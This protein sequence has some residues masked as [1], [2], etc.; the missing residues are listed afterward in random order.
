MKEWHRK[1]AVDISTFIVQIVRF[2]LP[3]TSTHAC[4][5]V[6]VCVFVCALSVITKVINEPTY[7]CAYVCASLPHSFSLL[8]SQCDCI[9]YKISRNSCMCVCVGAQCVCATRIKT[10]KQNV[11]WLPILRSLFSFFSF[12]FV[13]QNSQ[14]LTISKCQLFHATC[15]IKAAQWNEEKEQTASVQDKRKRKK[16][17]SKADKKKKKKNRAKAS[18]SIKSDSLLKRGKQKQQQ[19]K[20]KQQKRNQK[21]TI[22]I[23]NT[24]R[25]ATKTPL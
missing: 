4:L 22:I 21:T 17:A 6:C 16:A 2:S 13:L 20:Q 8:P 7:A 12:F 18:K 9:Y 3:H 19:Q 25:R 15:T 23:T 14:L 5:C 24:T 11:Y 10:N 1:V